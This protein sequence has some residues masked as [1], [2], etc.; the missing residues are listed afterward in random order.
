MLHRRCGPDFGEQG[1]SSVLQLLILALLAGSAGLLLTG[2]TGPLVQSLLGSPQD[3]ASP[4]GFAHTADRHPRDD[5]RQVAPGRVKSDVTPSHRA[6]SLPTKVKP[7]VVV[8]LRD[9]V[10][11]GIVGSLEPL[12]GFARN[13]ALYPALSARSLLVFAETPLRRVAGELAATVLSGFASCGHVG[14]RLGFCVGQ[15]IG[16][17]PLLFPVVGMSVMVSTTLKTSLSHK[18]VSLG[19][20][21]APTTRPQGIRRPAMPDVESLIGSHVFPPAAAA[22]ATLPGWVGVPHVWGFMKAWLLRWR[23]PHHG[24]TLLRARRTG[25]DYIRGPPVPVELVQAMIGAADAAPASKSQKVAKYHVVT[26]P[27]LLSQIAGLMRADPEAGS[28][29]PLNQ[30]TGQRRFESSVPDSAD[31]I[32]RAG[33]VIVFEATSEFSEGRRALLEHV[34]NRAQELSQLSPQSTVAFELERIGMGTVIQSMLLVV[35]D[36]NFRRGMFGGYRVKKRPPYLEA[37][38][39]GDVLIAMDKIEELLGFDGDLAGAIVVGWTNVKPERRPSLEERFGRVSA[40]G[41]IHWHGA[42]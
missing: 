2:L 3:M 23:R 16:P 29:A 6:A 18:R 42:L 12:W 5:V 19:S 36:F 11:G 39:V 31:V 37:G 35:T 17:A 32:E 13:P 24:R 20:S 10:V 30:R 21:I 38:Y 15:F 26:D 41:S 1:E 4:V 34:K 40:S 27:K 7:S 33:A 28:Y 8:F 9:A 25:R 22:A 14:H